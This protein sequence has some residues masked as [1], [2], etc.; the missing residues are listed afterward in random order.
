MTTEREL[1]E[2]YVRAGKLMQIATI[3]PDG[4]PTI[5]NAWYDAH[6]APDVLRFIS[7]DYRYHSGNIRRDGRVA[8]NI[9][10]IE[11]EA[12]GQT[13]RGVS[14]TGTAR[15]LP[16]TGVTTEANAFLARWPEAAD[17]VAP[18]R[19]AQA[20]SPVRLYEIVVFEWILFDEANF[21]EQP[22]RAISAAR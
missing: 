18:H 2:E 11:L 5:C 19:L 17:A 22:R 20:D 9:I 12:L 21:A 16:T 4:S 6:F 14:F 7:R 10:A 8:G 13:A 3:N 15:E 1:L